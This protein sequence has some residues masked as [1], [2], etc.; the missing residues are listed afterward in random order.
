MDIRAIVGGNLRKIRDK[1]KLTQ[2]KLSDL[3]GFSQQYLSELESGKRNPTIRSLSEIARV[4]KVDPIEF[5]KE[6]GRTSKA[7]KSLTG[8]KLLSKSRTK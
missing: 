1:R 4:L 2:E 8:A 3:S 5:F 6:L 7:H